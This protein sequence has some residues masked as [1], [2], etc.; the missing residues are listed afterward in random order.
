VIAL[1]TRTL[2]FQGV[3][4]TG[5]SYTLPVAIVLYGGG[6]GQRWTARA[7][8]FSG[9]VWLSLSPLIGEDD[10]TLQAT[11][12]VGKLARGTYT[13]AITISAD[14]QN[15]PQV[16]QVIFNVRDPQPAAMEVSSAALRFQAVAGTRDPPAQELA[17]WKQGDLPLNWRASASTASGGNWLNVSPASGSERGRLTVRAALGTLGPGEYRGAVTVASEEAVNSPLAVQV[18]FAVERAAPVIR[19]SAAALSF[20]AG[21]EVFLPPPQ[22]LAVSNDGYGTLNW[23]ASA[24]TFNGGAWLSVVAGA[25]SMTVAAD[26][27]GL[28]SGAYT[29]RVTVTAEGA[30][31]SPLHVAVTL[32]VTRPR[33]EFRA[34]TVVN[35][36]SLRG[37]PVTPEEILSIFGARL[38]PGARA[39]FDGVAAQVLYSSP[40]QL[41]LVVPPEVAG[42]PRVRLT[43]EVENLDLAELELPVAPAAPG[44]FTVDGQRAAVIESPVEAGGV[45]QMF[46]TGLRGDVAVNIN[47]ID[48]ALIYAGPAPGLLGVQQVNAEVPREVGASEWVRVIVKASGVEAPPVFIAVRPP[49]ESPRP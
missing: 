38:G 36:A 19:V 14:A 9:G 43:V 4:R 6:S 25:G 42:K 12:T 48:A 39:R 40:A 18:T 2:E 44:I 22:V 47:A 21:P 8:T 3:A 13:G 45:V 17:I 34:E 26:G 46:G 27:M 31:N 49:S 1:S 5:Q 35:A 33:P 28:P 24:V 20:A 37:G 15:S 7:Q 11:A 23:R 41:N 29:G 10:A 32:T 16:I 30:A